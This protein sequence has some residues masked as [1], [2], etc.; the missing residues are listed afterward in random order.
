MEPNQDLSKLI[1]NGQEYDP[2]EAQNFIERGKQTIEAE[3]KWNTSLDKVWPEYG[4]S[5]ET[6]KQT[7]SELT[8]AKTQLAEFQSKKI[9]GTDTQEDLTDAREAARKL[10]LILKDD[11]DESGYIKKDDLPKLFQSFQ[12][13]QDAV[14]QVLTTADKLEGEIDGSD[15][16][17]KFNKKVVLAYANSYGKTDLLE[18]YEEMHEDTLK[19][20]KDQKIKEKENPA[21]KTFNGGD[22]K[23]PKRVPVTDD[24]LKDLLNE[25]LGNK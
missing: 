25:K 8:E 14:K 5:Q 22:K 11:L 7:Q 4:K 6:L 19:V 10:G 18:A 12:A 1:I 13:E 15:G 20:W 2:A 9:K 16:R 23:E 3:R 17:P 21:L 24:N